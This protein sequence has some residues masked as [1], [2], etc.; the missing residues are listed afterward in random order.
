M[1]KVQVEIKKNDVLKIYDFLNQI[2]SSNKYFIEFS[3]RN[4]KI[5]EVEK[6]ILEKS[7]E[8]T[9]KENEYLKSEFEIINKYCVKRKNGDLEFPLMVKEGEEDNY[10]NEMTKLKED[11]LDIYNTIISKNED[12]KKSLE[13]KIKLE[14]HQINFE[15]IPD[16]IN[17]DMYELLRN[18]ELITFE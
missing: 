7:F 14:L 13:E 16:E 11:N 9:D 8:N 10:A 3:I 12:R 4:K 17:S 15:R 1:N 2:K 5:L 6:E 18:Y